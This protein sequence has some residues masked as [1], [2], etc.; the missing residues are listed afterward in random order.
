MMVNAR[1]TPRTIGQAVAELQR[2]YPDLSASSLRFL[3]REGLIRPVRTPGGHRLFRPS[4]IARIRRIKEWQA[5][6]LS[7]GEIRERLRTADRMEPA[8][9]SQ[10]FLEH[11][12]RGALAAATRVVLN[13]DEAGLPLE[14]SFGEVLAPALVAVGDLWADG[15]LQ[16]GQEHEISS[17]VSDLIAELTF[18]HA[19]AIANGP[20]VVA[21]CVDDERH[22]I[23][24][25]MVAGLLR[26]DGL[27]VH[28]LGASVAPGILRESVALRRPAVILLSVT[29]PAHL[30]QIGRAIEALGPPGGRP[31]VVAGGQACFARPDAARAL[32]AIVPTC[33]DPARPIADIVALAGASSD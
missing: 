20:A 11:A 22:D 3:E 26:A 8:A 16:V 12:R 2:T 4:D 10:A 14:T 23:G 6:R 5:R 29:L 32:G 13:A 27:A 33:Q 31:P 9:L 24:M 28:F 7:L 15:T 21:A 25:R 17:L 1:P 18:R 19:G 30:D